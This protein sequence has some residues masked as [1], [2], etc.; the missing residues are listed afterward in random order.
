MSR[1]FKHV[2]IAAI[3]E[4]TLVALAVF[5]WR[6]GLLPWLPAGGP[7]NVRAEFILI[8]APAWFAV[9]AVFAGRRLASDRPRISDSHRRFLEGSMRVGAAFIVAIQGFFAYVD[10]SGAT[11]NRELVVRGAAVFLGLWMTIHGNAAAKIDPPSGDGAPAAGI[12]TRALLRFGWIMVALGLG[13][14]FFALVLPDPR[15]LR[16]VMI[17]IL[18]VA[19]ALEFEYRR[20]TRPGRPA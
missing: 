8:W 20:M 15:Q 2:A 19:V 9:G 1:A 17:A 11:F 3:I 7:A 16:P 6:R 5:A 18:V 12:W 4:M 14:V 10:V 13:L